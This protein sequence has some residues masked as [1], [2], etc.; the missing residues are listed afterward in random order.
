MGLGKTV[1]SIA[2]ISYLM[3]VKKN[4]GPFLIVVPLSTL[5][6]WTNEFRKWAPACK[7]VIYKGSINERRRIFKEEI[8]GKG[9]SRFNCV[10][11]TYEFIMRDKSY[12]KRIEWMCIIVDE[13]H[14]MKNTKSKFTMT[15]GTVY[16]SRYRV[17]LTGTPLQ[18]NL[19]ELWSLL[20]FLLPKI[21][22]SCD[23]FE[24][25]FAKPFSNFRAAGAG[26]EV[27][28][29]M[30]EEE[31]MLVINR[32]HQVLRPFLLRRLKRDVIGKMPE[33]VEKILRCELSAW[34]ELQYN[35]IQDSGTAALEG[36][37]QRQMQNTVMQL[38]KICNHPYLF[39]Q[40]WRFDSALV[41]SSG[42]FALLDNILPKLKVF[43]HRVLIFSQMTQLMN[44]MEDCE[45]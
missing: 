1:Q 13:G 38:R 37:G 45:F 44:I 6:N 36:K 33:K 16:R 39:L 14:R 32:L 25:W 5:S 11:T 30:T 15:L 22:K 21:F 19:P 43:G 3:E 27:K 9:E 29:E 40:Q 2:L 31:N 35:R 10:V 20:N 4:N 17:L 23:S 41:R 7:C 42:K 12:L 34:Q 8:T 24:E 18:N 28:V 26:N